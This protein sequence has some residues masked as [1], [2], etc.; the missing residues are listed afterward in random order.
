[1]IVTCYL[2]PER[3]TWESFL[4]YSVLLWK[5]LLTS[6]ETRMPPKKNCKKC[7]RR[8]NSHG[9]VLFVGSAF[10]Q[11]GNFSLISSVF[12]LWS[13]MH[14]FNENSRNSKSSKLVINRFW[15]WGSLLLEKCA[16]YLT[17]LDSSLTHQW[18]KI[19]SFLGYL[20]VEWKRN[21]S[22]SWRRWIWWTL[23]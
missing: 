17:T 8:C 16:L 20:N 6:G 9:W 14:L 18:R 11:D 7:M 3:K 5:I 19:Y 21:R 15:L 1:M 13:E 23:K 2:R 12:A 10:S 4:F 22:V